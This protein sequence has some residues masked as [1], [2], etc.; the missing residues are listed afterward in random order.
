MKDIEVC[1]EV[2]RRV[3]AVFSVEDEEAQ[4][5]SEGVL[6]EYIRDQ[7][8]ETIGTQ[9]GAEFAIYDQEE[10]WTATDCETG[11]VLQDWR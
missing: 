11:K 4:E 3:S 9:P 1:F 7:M 10:D 6:P 8:M 5:I 2:T